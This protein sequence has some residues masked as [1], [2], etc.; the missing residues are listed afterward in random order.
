MASAVYNITS[1]QVSTGH[2]T[3]VSHYLSNAH[4]QKNIHK[5]THHIRAGQNYFK[6][7]FW[8]KNYI[9]NIAYLITP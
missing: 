7:H 9:R 6:Q 4:Q 3:T 8:K 2:V 5:E 1:S